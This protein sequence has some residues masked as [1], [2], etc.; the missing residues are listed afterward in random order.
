MVEYKSSLNFLHET[1]DLPSSI[2]CKAS[3]PGRAY[4]G[5]ELPLYISIVSCLIFNSVIHSFEHNSTASACLHS[6]R[7]DRDPVHYELSDMVS[8]LQEYTNILTLL[9]FA[10]TFFRTPTYIWIMLNS[11]A[12]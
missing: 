5:F 4:K 1:I 8:Y 10:L 3:T 6:L 7:H 2:I 9:V 12:T 11:A